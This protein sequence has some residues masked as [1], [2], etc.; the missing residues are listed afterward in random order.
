MMMSDHP[1]KSK[2][3]QNLGLLCELTI[4]D[5]RKQSRNRALSKFPIFVREKISLSQVVNRENA[6]AEVKFRYC[7]GF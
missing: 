2:Q 3:M 7:I 1:Q 4:C 5:S 6:T